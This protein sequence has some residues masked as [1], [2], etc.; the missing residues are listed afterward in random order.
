MSESAGA[1]CACSDESGHDHSS[2]K[3]SRVIAVATSGTLACLGIG[4]NFLDMPEL[5]AKVLLGGS[6][7]SG[8]VLVLPHAWSAIR[9]LSPDMNLLMAV[10]VA[11]AL[12]IGAWDE[13]ATVVFLFSLSELL[14]SFSA[15]RARRAITGLL[16]LVPETALVVTP[17][18][19]REVPAAD[20]RV[21]DR[22]LIRPGDRIS[23][24]GI[25]DEGNSYVNQAPITGES[26]PVKK[27]K[28]NQVFAG[29]INGEGALEVLVAKGASETTLAR[30]IHL[31]ESAQDRKADVQRFVDRFAFYYT[32]FV[33]AFALLIAILP[34][35]TFG[36]DWG[37]WVYRALVLLVIAC[38]CALV[39]STPIA[40][41][42]A[43]A[44]AARTGVLIKGG[45]ALEALARIGVV[46]LDKTGTLTEGK[47]S[48]IDVLPFGESSRENV[49]NVACSLEQ[50]SEHPIA[51][52]IR[53]FG[54]VE[55]ISLTQVEGFEAKPGRG[56]VGVINGHQYFIGNHRLVEEFNLC[57]PGVERQ[58][59]DVE[60]RTQ[61][62]VI[63][64]HAPHGTCEGAVLGAMAVGDSIREHAPDAIRSLRLAGV[65][66]IVMLTGDNLS[67]A[68]AVARSLGIDEVHAE[69]LPEEKVS[70][71]EALI[72]GNP[73][74]VAMVGDGVNDAPALA[75][76]SVGVAMGAAG[77]DAAIEAADVALMGDDLQ[78]L[79]T[80]IRIGRQARRIIFQ[81]IV[82]A[83]SLKGAFLCLAVA[84]HASM[85]AAVA[86]DTG[87]SLVVIANGFRCRNADCA[88]LSE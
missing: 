81:N 80:A 15:I 10:A 49:L 63:V 44:A 16:K 74:A 19:S 88:R 60:R 56:A 82:I 4:A 29:T 39:I 46:A 12:F 72:R 5:L 47:P 34:P 18:G 37:I 25:V 28:G 75:L 76:A 53:T 57:T 69:L 67:T 36:G 27:S 14:E 62:A 48:V 84:G 87:A 78:K 71:I 41:V 7:V 70:Q 20:V 43:L 86:A 26:I 9:R 85:W 33:M 21:G 52:A 31:V 77:S 8:G 58:V 40:V 1:S 68:D 61:T 45:V 54:E 30:L 73:G 64:G 32:P 42:S 59:E 50:R 38:P 13:A 51:R 66:R 55:A 79:S 83:L 2:L 3:R 11:G 6:V 17:G 35:L 22:I 65:H 24:D 23:L